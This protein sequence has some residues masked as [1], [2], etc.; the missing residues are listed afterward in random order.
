MT[1]SGVK[2]FKMQKTKFKVKPCGK[3][4]LHHKS[5]LNDPTLQPRRLEAH[6]NIF[7]IIMPWLPDLKK[8]EE[9]KVKELVKLGL[10]DEKEAKRQGKTGNVDAEK[11]QKQFKQKKLGFGG[12]KESEK[13]E[14]SANE[15]IDLV[16]PEKA[17]LAGIKTEAEI[18]SKSI[19]I[20]RVEEFNWHFEDQ[21]NDL[22]TGK[23]KNVRIDMS[24]IQAIYI[25]PRWRK[26]PVGSFLTK[27]Q[28][29]ADMQKI[30]TGK[31]KRLEE[32]AK[33][34]HARG[35]KKKDQSEAHQDSSEEDEAAEKAR[36]DAAS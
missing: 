33:S 32:E 12:D 22:V 3:F 21:L 10:I 13:V 8:E 6:E 15:P 28:T 23:P 5:H 31:I 2:N 25:N 9:D 34:K 16:T 14:S 24:E 1:P 26:M 7:D 17:D 20:N 29:K 19:K 35:R 27:L 18:Y 4:F 30:E 11:L 36:R